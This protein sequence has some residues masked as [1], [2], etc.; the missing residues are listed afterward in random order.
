MLRGL[1]AILA[2]ACLS[3]S[4]TGAMDGEWKACDTASVRPSTSSFDISRFT[5]GSGPDSTTLLGPFTAA[6]DTSSVPATP[7]SRRC[8]SSR[9]LATLSSLARTAIMQPSP[10]GSEYI[11]RARSEI[12]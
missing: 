9:A 8:I 12:R 7:E 2:T 10:F 5:A 1:N 3:R 6:I 11:S 4:A